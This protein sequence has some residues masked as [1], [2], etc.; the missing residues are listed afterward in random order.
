MICRRTLAGYLQLLLALWLSPAHA[1]DNG[2][3]CS[4]GTMPVAECLDGMLDRWETM[5]SAERDA[6]P[7]NQ[8]RLAASLQALQR[9]MPTLASTLTDKTDIAAVA[10]AQQRITL[11]NEQLARQYRRSWSRTSLS[12][13]LFSNDARHHW[14]SMAR[15]EYRLS[16]DTLNT[17]GQRWQAD[18][19]VSFSNYRDMLSTLLMLALAIAI[20]IGLHRVSRRS[21]AL[22]LHLHNLIVERAAKRR[23]VKALA[24][25]FSGLAPLAPW[26]LLWL[27]LGVFTALF[28]GSNAPLLLWWAPLAELYIIYGLLCLI[29]EW[30]LLRICSGAG[31]FLS[32]E[33]TQQLTV[34]ARIH[35]RWLIW[36][37]IVLYLIDHLV[38][39]SL[40]Y[41]V[42]E[43]LGWA[44]IW[45]VLASLLRVRHQ[46]YLANLKRMLPEAA[47][48]V[49][50]RLLADKRFIFFA[51]L[52]LPLQLLLFIRQYLDQLLAD[53]D[54]YRS[55]S[56]RW[57]RMRTKSLVEQNAEEISTEEVSEQYERWFTPEGEGTS[58]LPVIDTGLLQ[59]LH[60]PLDTWLKNRSDEN[61]LLVTGEKG[62]GKS[63][64]LDRLE[65]YIGKEVPDIV[66]L[67]IT[68]PA[69]TTGKQAVYE[70][71]GGT[72][73]VDLGDGPAV[74]AR[75]DEERKP[76]VIMLD[77][78]Q[79][80]FLAEVGHLDGWR[81][82]L[83]LTNIRL[84][85]IF[86]VVAINNQSWAYLCNVFG[87]EY[88][89]RTAIRAKR[90]SQNEIRSLIL[91]RNHLS[92]YKIQYDDIL[93][94]TRGPDAGNLR[95]AEQRYFS[96]LWDSCHGV[97]MT[98][99]EM[100][101]TSIR[102]NGSTVTVGLP[103]I[104]GSGV[105]ER[106]GSK[107][108]FVYAAIATHENLT[109][110]EIIMVTNQQENVVRYALKS[111][112]D[113]DFVAR[114]EDG[115]YRITPLWY[116]TVISYLTRK[117]MLH[118]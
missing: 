112:L 52:L 48:P 2:P 49:V 107:L 93:L 66:V 79:N 1:D 89:M 16:A 62:I 33:Q 28:S 118:E 106:L 13:G 25:L 53:F 7:A 17:I 75:T 61:S 98:A 108:M 24:R 101:L 70:L 11:L 19:S 26:I 113:A 41:C 80:L 85:N 8:A 43:L 82:L 59:A 42:T 10:S 60:K 99:L 39:P 72:L 92:G 58:K 116:H 14:R 74:L 69:K 94:A 57:F 12:E 46:E 21:T 32:S 110:E 31:I 103:Q 3:P 78:A 63:A 54:W 109:F 34:Q 84:R 51:T 15:Y 40:L 117:N 71:I 90:W 20:F 18:G 64:A 86:W 47:D 6:A 22:L 100:W 23:W 27:A 97:P 68:V 37:W 114:S 4:N 38:G 83:S 111:A 55:L 91:S 5:V 65:Q 73:G 67:R 87:R 29:G 76:T 44:V 56:A 30:L 81:T 45:F 35:S 105:L 36:P 50:D 96:L 102:T 77:E 104:P 115:R 9:D 95:N 88:Q